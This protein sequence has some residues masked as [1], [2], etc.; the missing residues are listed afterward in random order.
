LRATTTFGSV[1]L[2]QILI[3]IVKSKIIAIVLGPSGFGIISLFQSTLSLIS[4]LVNLGVSTSAVQALSS[5]NVGIEK[6][7]FFQSVRILNLL[8]IS[9][10]L[11]GVIITIIFSEKLSLMTFG[12]S[13]YK[14]AFIILSVTILF[15]QIYAGHLVV[16]QSSRNQNLLAKVLIYSN[17]ISLLVLVLLLYFV[18]A[19]A[20]LIFILLTSLSSVLVSYFFYNKLK[21]DKVSITF[22]DFKDESI[23]LLQIGFFVSLGGVTTIIFSYLLKLFINRYGSI[24]DVGFFNACFTIVSSYIGIIFSAMTLDYFPKLSSISGNIDDINNAINHQIEITFILISPLIATFLIFSESIINILYSPDFS[25]INLFLRYSLFSV[26]FKAISWPIAYLFIVRERKMLYFLNELVAAIFMFILNIVGYKF[27]GL[28]GV[29]LSYIIGYILYVLQVYFISKKVYFF[30]FT[31]ETVKIIIINIV[32]A[33]FLLIITIFL[34][35]A[36]ASVLKYFL[37]LIVLSINLFEL[38]K[39]IDLR[40]KINQI[41]LLWKN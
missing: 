6:K 8:L 35:D 12:N 13:S 41:I 17:I 7:Y 11:I 34:Y 32:L 30:K 28:K 26:F 2:F 19:Q 9:T 16:I 20:I 29:G 40:E 21:L 36:F 37:L 3:G 33:F 31:S 5:K 25:S 18:N 23:R 15:G 22:R 4:S 39:R 14:S 1:Q 38:N 27:G 24:N 10:G